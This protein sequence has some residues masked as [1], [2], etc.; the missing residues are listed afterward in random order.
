MNPPESDLDR[1]PLKGRA[2]DVVLEQDG[3]RH[4]WSARGWGEAFTAYD[5]ISHVAA[6]ERF[7]WIASRR[8]L[9]VLSRRRFA[10]EE[11]PER[12][13]RGIVERMEG[14]PGGTEQLARMAEIDAWGRDPVAPRV[15]RSVALLC[16]LLFGLQALYPPVT[17]VAA[18]SP[19]LFVDGDWWRLLTANLLHSFPLHFLVNLI[20]LLV[21]GRLAERALGPVRTLCVMGASALGSMAASGLL[22]DGAVVGVSGVLFG[23]A[24]AV[25]F[26]EVAR[27]EELP[28]WWRFPRVLMWMVWGALVVEVTLGFAVPII[29]GEAHLGGMVSGVLATALITRGGGLRAPE[30]PWVRNGAALTVAVT[31]VAIGAAGESWLGADDFTAEHAA[32]LVDIPSIAAEELNNHAWL[33]AIDPAHTREQLKAALSLAE[34]AVEDTDGEEA[35]ILDTLAEVQFQLGRPE[36]AV[37]TIDLAIERAPNDSHTRYYTEQRR[38]FTGERAANDRPDDP[39]FLPSWGDDSDGP[40]LLPPAEDGLTV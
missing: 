23:L 11:D 9:T 40:P 35:T 39:S 6:S 20:G 27:P 31:L 33:I 1:F 12:L 17:A 28:A 34:R 29:A 21:V 5:D 30:R 19:A 15:T 36:Q 2:R 38:R 16:V 32:R 8:A 7:V 22:V 10:A 13:L 18:F 14:R 26:L 37:L 24:G 4:P 3:I 25:L